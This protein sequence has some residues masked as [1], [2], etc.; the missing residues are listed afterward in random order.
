MTLYRSVL[1][2]LLI[3]FYGSLFLI[4]ALGFHETYDNILSGLGII[5]FDWPFVD[6]HG[7]LSAAQCH[8]EG[9]DI[10]TGNP[11]DVL[12]RPFNYSPFWLDL[13]PHFVTTAYTRTLGTGLNLAFVG[14]VYAVLRPSSW[15][16][17]ACLAVAC[18]STAVT[19]AVERGN[20]DLLIFALAA[21]AVLLCG[22]GR[23]ARLVAYATCFIAGLLK[24]YPFVLLTIALHEPPKRFMKIAATS[25]AAL[26]VFVLYYRDAILKSLSLVSTGS[27]FTDLF[28]ATNLPSGIVE[29]YYG[30]FGAHDSALAFAIFLAAAASCLGISAFV[31]RSFAAQATEIDWTAHEARCLLVGPL[32]IVGCF[33][34][35]QSIGYRGIHLLFALAG[36]MALRR[37]VRNRALGRL[38]LFAIGAILLLMWE[39]GIRHSFEFVL[40]A[41]GSDDKVP[42]IPSEIFWLVRELTWWWV[43]SVLSTIVAMFAL[44]S[45]F[46][47]AVKSAWNARRPLSG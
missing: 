15:R 45:P 43:V 41:I 4:R 17:V 24:F 22:L 38:L 19:F 23:T 6:S 11:C 10:F 30:A 14:A 5:P 46:A 34:A 29:L 7:I 9:A 36:L 2:V 42:G 25:S 12:N 20:A 8:R 21:L 26:V 33:F 28:G 1:P 3:C 32:L 13:V 37:S 44:Q 27:Y 16:E 40:H 31:V 47:R 39:E 18:T 35:G